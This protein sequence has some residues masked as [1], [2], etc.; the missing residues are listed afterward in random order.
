MHE[1][2]CLESLKSVIIEIKR[3]D[4]GSLYVVDDKEEDVQAL[5]MILDYSQFV[6]F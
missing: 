3:K 6:S 1:K 2:E 5:R 4:D